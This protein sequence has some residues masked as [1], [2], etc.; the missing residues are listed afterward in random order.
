MDGNFKIKPGAECK[1]KLPFLYEKLPA[2]FTI[3]IT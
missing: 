2:G 3:K 1:L